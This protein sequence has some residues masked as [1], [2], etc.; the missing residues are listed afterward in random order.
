LLCNAPGWLTNVTCGGS[1][2]YFT[3]VTDV[4]VTAF[5]AGCGSALDG[6][7]HA[8]F[9]FSRPTLAIDGCIE[10]DSE[11]SI[12][13]L[14]RELGAVQQQKESTERRRN[15]SMPAPRQQRTGNG[16]S[17]RILRTLAR[18]RRRACCA[19]AGSLGFL[20]VAHRTL[21]AN[22]DRYAAFS[23]NDQQPSLPGSLHAA[24]SSGVL[25]VAVRRTMYE[26]PWPSTACACIP[27]IWNI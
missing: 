1:Y 26:R 25:Q 24:S 27:L 16:P 10:S 17:V 5:P 18:T 6:S 8:R 21:S 19:Q 4:A 15:I 12:R 11:R 7:R 2:K 9:P 20:S 13:L 3:H 14:K 23:N 22:D